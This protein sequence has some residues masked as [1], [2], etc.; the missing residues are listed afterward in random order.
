MKNYLLSYLEI[1][2][3][4][5][6]PDIDQKNNSLIV[7][8]CE[9]MKPKLTLRMKVPTDIAALQIQVKIAYE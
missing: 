6:I 3:K 9:I 5:D 4:Y 2:S 8:R 7:K 1:T